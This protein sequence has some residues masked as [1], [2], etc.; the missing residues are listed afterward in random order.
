MA[1]GGHGILQSCS[2]LLGRILLVPICLFAKSPISFEVAAAAATE[3]ANITH[4]T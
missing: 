4:V 1:I 2:G 3:K